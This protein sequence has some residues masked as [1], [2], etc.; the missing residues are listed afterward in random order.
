MFVTHPGWKGTDDTGLVT[1]GTSPQWLNSIARVGP[2]KNSRTTLTGKGTP[3]A[4]M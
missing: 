2:P 3:E 1:V 4:R